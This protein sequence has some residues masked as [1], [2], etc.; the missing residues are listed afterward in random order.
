MDV[1]IPTLG[2]ILLA[3]IPAAAS[4]TQPSAA[5]KWSVWLHETSF[6]DYAGVR[7]PDVPRGAGGYTKT[8]TL[9]SPNLGVGYTLNDRW[10]VETSLQLGPK[11][12]FGPVQAGAQDYPRIEFKS[13]FVSVMAAREFKL[14]DGWSWAPKVGVAVSS[15]Y[16]DKDVQDDRSR[17]W[18]N[19]LN[20]VVSVE[21]RKPITERVS[22]STDYT[23]YFT[24]ESEL[25]G[26]AKIGLRLRF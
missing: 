8:V 12:S 7:N 1:R 24:E 10:S 22:F 23:R 9:F 3:A 2:A 21:L 25:N 13:R 16:V 14:R 4:N 6:H 5:E 19:S 15:R 17:T 26:A 20:P 18:T 11:S